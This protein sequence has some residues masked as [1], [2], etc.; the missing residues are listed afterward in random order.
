M[1]RRIVIVAVLIA[2]GCGRIGGRGSV[3]PEKQF[4]RVYAQ[5]LTMGQRGR[6]E[7][8]DSVR[9]HQAADSV[10]RGAGIGRDEY[11]ATVE[12][13]NEDVTRWTRVSEE[14]VRILEERSA[15]RPAG[16]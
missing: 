9:T 4:A 15:G 11:R 3:M 16:P 6:A 12:W 8:W 14:T 1:N 10:L 7:G 5:L 13:L 2:A